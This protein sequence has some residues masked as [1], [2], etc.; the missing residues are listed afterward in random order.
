L[1]KQ[2]SNQSL[3]RPVMKSHYWVASQTTGTCGTTRN[4][5]LFREE[6]LDCSVRSD[7]GTIGC[8]ARCSDR[9]KLSSILRTTCRLQHARLHLRPF[10]GLESF[11]MDFDIVMIINYDSISNEYLV[12]QAK[13]PID[14]CEYAREELCNN[15]AE[16][17]V[18]SVARHSIPN[19]SSP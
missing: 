10:Q 11:G 18:H 12:M 17:I 4:D 2:T 8:N 6:C 3:F 7:T 1:Q 14:G 9:L 5:I 16:H 19:V 15:Q 13:Q